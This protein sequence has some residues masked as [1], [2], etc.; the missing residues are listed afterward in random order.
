MKLLNLDK[1]L[2]EPKIVRLNDKEYVFKKIPSKFTLKLGAIKETDT[3][4]IMFP[5]LTDLFNEVA[6]AKMDKDYLVNN[7]STDEFTEVVHYLF[8][9]AEGN[10]EKNEASLT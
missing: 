1:L 10:D 4:D 5:I 2:P 8:G 9:K 6:G 3:T 7:L